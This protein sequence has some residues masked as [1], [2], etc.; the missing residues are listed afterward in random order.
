MTWIIGDIHGEK[1]LLLKLLDKID[2]EEHC[3][4][5]GER[6][7]ENKHSTICSRRGWDVIYSVGD[8]IDRGNNSLD[9]IDICVNKN[10]KVVKG[11]HEDMCIDYYFKE[12]RYQDDIW[13][14]NGGNKTLDELIAI[15]QDST[16]ELS[17]AKKKVDNY[18][19][20]MKNLPL[21]YLI[22]ENTLISHAGI[23]ADLKSECEG[24]HP[25]I[26]WNRDI[27]TNKDYFQIFGHTPLENGPKITSKYLNIDTGAVFGNGLTA[28]H[29]PDKKVITVK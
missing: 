11:N 15:I 3:Y 12:K 7:K 18:I 28:I 6:R 16:I 24:S 19:N 20:W 26:F 27:E 17:E 2:E 1:E 21:Y 13:E 5:C 4:I 10:I 14:S 8:I 29:L 23:V 9:C 25:G 22:E